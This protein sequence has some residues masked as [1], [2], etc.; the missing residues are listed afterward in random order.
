MTPDPFLDEYAGGMR[1][2]MP[3]CAG[4]VLAAFSVVSI[5]A[6][7]VLLVAVLH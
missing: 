3:G 5:A 2:E 7:V 6:A 4:W 1:R